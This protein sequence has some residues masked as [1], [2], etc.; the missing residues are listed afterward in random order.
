MCCSSGSLIEGFAAVLA[1]H[2]ICVVLC[3]WRFFG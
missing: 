3:V 1:P 2:A